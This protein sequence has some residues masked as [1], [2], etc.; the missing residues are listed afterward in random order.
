MGVNLDIVE[1]KELSE[2][3]GAIGRMTSLG[4]GGLIVTA[5]PVFYSNPAA[6]TNHLSSRTSGKP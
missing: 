6:I 2:L 4:I 5:D 1:V 3:D